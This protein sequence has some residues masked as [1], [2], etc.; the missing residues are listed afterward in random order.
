MKRA[1]KGAV[2][3][4]AAAAVIIFSG[5]ASAAPFE[6]GDVF[7]AVSNGKV[8]HYNSSG[9]LVETLDTGHGGLTTGM[10][11]DASGNLYVANHSANSISRFT[12]A[13]NPHEE[14]L[15]G[16]PLD[17][18]KPESIIFD[19]A[20]NLWTGSGCCG[21]IK[22]IDPSGNTLL[23]LNTGRRADWIQLSPDETKIYYTENFHNGIRVLDIA[24]GQHDSMLSKKYGFS[25]F[26]LLD[27]GGVLVSHKGTV[28]RLDAQGNLV[29]SYDIQGVDQWF[30]LGLD[31]DGSSF[32]SGSVQ[33]GSL[34]KFDIASGSLLQTINTGAG[35][36]NLLGV[37]VYTGGALQSLSYNTAVPE[38]GTLLM[39]GSALAFLYAA[40]KRRSEGL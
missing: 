37:A 19:S 2:S 26:Q 21:T 6:Y 35:A 30:A 25:A 40:G 31:T 5:N 14:S 22:K 13:G 34:Y 24:T 8:Q 9:D 12:G 10:N 33:N 20:G 18:K 32:W 11:F 36:N 15:F 23:T 3:A 38:P 17:T 28:K 29:Q 1:Y 16:S 39:F 7:A 4:A 27:D